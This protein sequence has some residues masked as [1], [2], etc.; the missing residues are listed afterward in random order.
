[1]RQAVGRGWWASSARWSVVKRTVGS[2]SRVA[3]T[4]K[5]LVEREE[6][7]VAAKDRLISF[8]KSW[9]VKR[10]PVSGPPWAGSRRMTVRGAGCWAR[11]AMGSRV[12]KMARRAVMGL[13]RGVKGVDGCWLIVNG[14]G[15]MQAKDLVALKITVLWLRKE[16][17]PQG[18]KPRFC[19]AAEGPEP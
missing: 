10:A 5:P 8:S 15:E 9:L 4:V 6:R 12:A 16:S 3:M 2:L 17:I 13:R 18:L 1:M 19:C 7:R 11:S 14:C